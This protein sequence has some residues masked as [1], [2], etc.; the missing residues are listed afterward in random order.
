MLLSSCGAVEALGAEE[1][2]L[3]VEVARGRGMMAAL[4][5]YAA[6]MR[7]EVRRPGGERRLVR[8]RRLCPAVRFPEVR[9]WNQLLSGTW[10]LVRLRI[11]LVI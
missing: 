2:S 9:P 6:K 11:S 5:D 4:G 1:T 8:K 7:I 3:E 10:Q